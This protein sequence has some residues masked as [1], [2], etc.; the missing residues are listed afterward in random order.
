MMEAYTRRKSRI[1]RILAGLI[2]NNGDTLDALGAHLPGDD[3]YA[4]IAVIGLAAGHRDGIVVEDLV[5]DVDAR[6]DGSTD[7]EQ[8]RMI[9]GAIADILENVLA[10]GERRF[11][12][13]VGS[14][15]ALLGRPLGM[16][17][18]DEL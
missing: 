15:A 18:G 5:G 13:P 7:G 9:V 12:D 16:S 8:A 3:R 11:A 1:R 10:L 2:G 6:G 17:L 4:E 14:L